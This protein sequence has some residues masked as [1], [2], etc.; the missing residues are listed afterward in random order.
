MPLLLWLQLPVLF[1]L[2]LRL[3]CTWRLRVGNDMWRREPWPLLRWAWLLLLWRLLWR[4]LLRRL[5]LHLLLR[6]LLIQPLPVAFRLMRKHAPSS[7]CAITRLELIAYSR[8]PRAL[9]WPLP[10]GAPEAPPRPP[11][12][13]PPAPPRWWAPLPLGLL[14]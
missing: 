3:L 11:E 1:W 10:F 12:P 5:L 14:A 2:P 9:E 4:L 6:L 8:R 13:R 7:Q